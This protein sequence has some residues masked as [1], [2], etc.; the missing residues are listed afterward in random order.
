M[1]GRKL[2]LWVLIIIL[3]LFYSVKAQNIENSPHNLSVTGPGTIKA[4]SETELCVFCHT[5]HNSSPKAPLWNRADP[6][7]SYQVYNSSSVDAVIGQPDGSSL[8]CL[9]CHDGTIALGHVLS[10]PTDIGFSSGITTLPSG[11]TNLST[12]LSDDHPISFAYTSSLASSNPQLKNPNN[13][14]SALKLENGK[15]QCT[16]CHDPH[17]NSK[18]NFLVL[19]M[20]KS[21]LCKKCHKMTN[22]ANSE[23][24]LS[25]ATWNGNGVDPW[26]NTTYNTVEKNACRNC[27]SPHNAAGK[28]RLLNY[29][30]EED[31][32]LVCH[33]GNVAGKDIQSDF[34]K[35]YTHNV[36]IYNQ[37]H[38]PEEGIPVTSQ[39]VECVDCHNPHSANN[40]TASAPN[41]SGALSYVSGIDGDGNP[42]SNIT[43]EYQLC[44]KCH[45]DSPSKPGS[46]TPRVIDQ[47]NVR[48]EFDPSNPSYHPIEAPGKNNNVTTLIS[49]LTESSIIY[50]TDCH[51]SNNSSAAGP[52]GSI[53]PQILKYKYVTADNTTESYQNYELCYQCHDRNKIINDT[54]TKFG[55]EVH[56]KHVVGEKLPCNNCHDPHG[57]SS[58]QGNSTNNTNLINFR[59]DVVQ[60]YNG[61]L[62]FVDQGDHKGQ[63]YLQC[64]GERH[65]PKSY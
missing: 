25:T 50:C 59:S 14:H 58:S 64:H 49:P 7:A 65:D 51:A 12:D 39:H 22:W 52:H 35:P 37:I 6:G 34:L 53:Y 29:Q 8:L 31:N 45:A 56:R 48:L 23:H 38:Q 43:Y 26:P 42:V 30:N 17:D 9:S 21:N 47:D 61:Q 5:P 55:K 46:H 1:A 10:R 41:A 2:N 28:E 11:E 13:I 33:S 32:C 18:G 27:H 4:T 44:Y 63:C 19:S 36:Y 62:K 57:I 20:Y 3:A 40:A 24:K 16:T 15:L 54:S 60:P